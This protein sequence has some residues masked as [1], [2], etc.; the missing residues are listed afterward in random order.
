MTLMANSKGRITLNSL[1][2]FKLA[3]PET[4][5]G[6]IQQELCQKSA[7]MCNVLDRGHAIP[8]Q[9]IVQFHCFNDSLK[10]LISLLL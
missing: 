6:R 4:T 1:A 9:E 10:A 2:T 5:A 3:F 8:A 7:V